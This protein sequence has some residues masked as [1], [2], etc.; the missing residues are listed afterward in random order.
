MLN[1]L[2]YSNDNRGIPI[3]LPRYL[4]INLLT[5]L[6]SVCTYPLTY[7]PTWCTYLDTYMSNSVFTCI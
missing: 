3:H 1:Y 7:L 4:F 6:S 2:D 5:H